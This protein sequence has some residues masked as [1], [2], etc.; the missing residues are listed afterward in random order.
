[1]VT[2]RRTFRGRGRVA[3]NQ[4][5]ARI[6]ERSV[7]VIT[8]CEIETVGNNPHHRF[9]G[10]ADVW[11][12]N[13]APHGPPSDPNN[14]VEWIPH[15][16]WDQDLNILIDVTLLDSPGRRCMMVEAGPTITRSRFA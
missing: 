15:V 7:V 6:N 8:A 2:F 16:D 12:S 13:I 11:V 3:M 4:N 14:G 10:A 1:M 9:L 5:D